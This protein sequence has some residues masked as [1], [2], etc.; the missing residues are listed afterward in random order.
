MKII[1]IVTI[2]T[3]KLLSYVFAPMFQSKIT[4]KIH[5]KNLENTKDSK[6]QNTKLYKTK[7]KMF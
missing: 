3:A 4:L 5:K 7:F 2:L 1:I 6:N